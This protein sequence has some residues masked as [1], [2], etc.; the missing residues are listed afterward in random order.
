MPIK[1]TSKEYRI[2][3]VAV[4]VAGVSFA[5]GMKYF[6]RAF[7]EASIEFRVNRDESAPLAQKFLAERAWQIAGYRHAAIFDFDDSAKVYLER[8]QGLERMDKLTRGPVRLWRWSHRWFKPQQKEEFRVEV[9]P[10]GQVVGFEHEIPE[11][12]S[13]ANLDV[14]AARRLA[15]G[16]LTDVMH[17]DLAD[18]EFLETETEKRPARTDH[19]FTWKQKS[20]DLGDG[21]LRVSV[22]VDGDQVAGYRE[23]IKVPE[24][25]SRD[26]EKLR[27]H[28]LAAQLVDE[29]FWVLLTVAGV[30]I[31]IARLRDRDVPVRLSVVLG[32]TGAV[33][34]FLSRLNTF[35]LS[36][37]GYRTTDS[38]SSFVA[39][40]VGL[41]LLA[42]LGIGAWLFFLTASS[43]PVYREGY[44]NLIS[45]RRYL[46]WHGLRTRSFLIANVVGITLTFFFFAYQ[47]VFYLAANK[48]GA[49]APA[50]V[51]YSDLLQTRFPWVF[52]LLMGFL[53]AVTE[54]MQFRAFAI[55]FLRKHLRHGVVALVLAAFIWG[56]LHSGYPNQPF[57]IR[58]IEVGVGGVIMGFIMLR[59]GILATLIWHYSVDAFYGA[60]LLIRSSNPYMMASGAA[61]AGVM[62]LPLAVALAAYW[63][64]GTFT[65]EE[66]LTNAREGLSRA[67][68]PTVS[69]A[70]AAIRYEPLPQKRVMLAGILAVVFIA[71]A[72]LPAY[73]FGKGFKVSVTRQEA[74]RVADNY[75]I[76]RLRGHSDVQA[77]HRVAWLDENVDTLAARYILE[78]KSIEETDSIYRQATLLAVWKVRY[79]RPLEKEEYL[80]I[81][82]PTSGKVFADRHVLDENAPGPSLTADQARDLAAQALQQHGYRLQDFVLQNSEAEKKKA[83]EDYTLTWQAKP[84]D[85]R[86]V[87]EAL[88]RL[89]VDIAGDQVT[90]F[91]RL[92]KLPEAWER[93]RR[94]SHLINSILAA[95][96]YLVS[97]GLLTAGLILLVKQVRAGVMPW[98]RSVKVGALI[99]VA[100]LL[101]EANQFP[102]LEQAYPTSMPL[103]IF[104]VAIGV[105]FLVVPVLAGLGVW[106]LAA[107]VASLYP[108]IWG[109]LRSQARH[110]WRWD[111][112]VALGLALAAGAGLDGFAAWL[113]ARYHAFAPVRLELFPAGLNGFSPGA[114]AF[115]S[116]LMWSVTTAL[117]GG[118]VIYVVR[119]GWGRRAWWLWVAAA[120]VLIELGPAEAHSPA[121]FLVSWGAQFLTLVV[122]I[123]LVA[124]F[125]RDNVLAYISAAFA[126][127]VVRPLVGLGSEPSAFSRGNALLLAALVA[128][129]LGWLFLAPKAVTS[130]K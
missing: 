103:G 84:G 64:T 121:E 7:P 32:L 97:A 18:L 53:P 46:G 108:N 128:A 20:V 122:T 55:P 41:G 6:S 102:V 57:F 109:L 8:T 11:E 71:V 65:E 118:L 92:F 126:L 42:A 78:R 16:F 4:L 2:L 101:V 79:F 44:P 3:G 67:A 89:Q 82:D 38:Y 12:T 45:L 98:R 35:S 74:L 76:P 127:V 81:V 100:M 107:L 68:R 24:Q 115:F 56:F 21:S 129:V 25:W 51:K 34:Y 86:N 58:G 124:L 66:P 95:I 77:Y 19:T 30:M 15:E 52:V 37:Y 23:F 96:S 28:N 130:D 22:E 62:L 49:W 61:A 116:A 105:S 47:S 43:E 73:H 33:L 59:F 85:P 113:A 27:S 99:A 39:G 87:G 80:V 26:Y 63:R 123:A 111:A 88:Y 94:A 69:E 104:K 60:F 50:D 93:E 90:G 9:S 112:A 117:L 83:R 75:L 14:P 17:R 110:L 114:G 48:L 1:L 125:F 13:G 106:L 31:L 72:F 70:E 120:F 36:E 5:I 119:E 40:F 10:A 91:T 54:E 29:I